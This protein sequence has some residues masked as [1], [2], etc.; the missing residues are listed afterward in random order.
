MGRVCREYSQKYTTNYKNHTYSHISSIFCLLYSVEIIFYRL[1]SVE[2]IFYRLSPVERPWRAFSSLARIQQ[3]CCI[4]HLCPVEMIFYRLYS[5]EIIF[6][7][8][9]SVEIIFYRLYSVEI[10]AWSQWLADGE[11]GRSGSHRVFFQ[12]NLLVVACRQFL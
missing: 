12:T 11:N 10:I 5:V 7:R 6:Y 4:W 9:Y 2:I 8:L 3:F 1:Y